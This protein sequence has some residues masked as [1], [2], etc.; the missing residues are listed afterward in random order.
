MSISLLAEATAAVEAP[1]VPSAVPAAPPAVPSQGLH[2]PAN[3]STAT[4]L[5]YLEER[6]LRRW[7]SNEE[8]KSADGY[9]HA[10]ARRDFA[11]LSAHTPRATFAPTPRSVPDWRQRARFRAE[12]RF[13]NPHR[14]PAARLERHHLYGLAH[15][16][17][18]SR[19]NNDQPPPIS[20]DGRSARWLVTME[21]YEIILF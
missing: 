1:T 17:Y 6:R 10:D 5:K 13:F 19:Y 14:G 3:L 15:F 12:E 9:H 7:L 16:R 20:L 11:N 2:T 21:R 4:I 18:Y 8:E